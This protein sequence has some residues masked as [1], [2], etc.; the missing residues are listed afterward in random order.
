MTTLYRIDDRH[1]LIDVLSGEGV[2]KTHES[3]STQ[4]SPFAGLKL[5]HRVAAAAN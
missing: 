4:S 5:S 2:L 1:L 3:E